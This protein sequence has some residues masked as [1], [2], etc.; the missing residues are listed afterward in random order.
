VLAEGIAA[1]AGVPALRAQAWAHGIVGMVQAA[2]DWW[3]D[4]APCDRA[5]LVGELA[6]LLGGGYGW[7]PAER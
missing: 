3:L 7:G 1:E 6:A 2:G 4:D 5:G